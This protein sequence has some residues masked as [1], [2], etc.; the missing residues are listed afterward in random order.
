MADALLAD[1][2]SPDLQRAPSLVDAAL[3]RSSGAA[4]GTRSAADNEPMR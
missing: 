2:A 4:C 3:E 1:L